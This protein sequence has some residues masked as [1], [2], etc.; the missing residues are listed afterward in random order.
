M[1]LGS[2]YVPVIYVI[3]IIVKLRQEVDLECVGFEAAGFIHDLQL[4]DSFII[5][6][7]WRHLMRAI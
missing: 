5:Y 1:R 3:S 4:L 6:P 2:G 7:P